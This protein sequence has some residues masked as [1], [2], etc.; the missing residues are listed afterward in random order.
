MTTKKL[1]ALVMAL[2]MLT[3]LFPASLLTVGATGETIQIGTKEDWDTFANNVTNGTSYSGCTVKLTADIG[4]A[5]NPVT[6]MVGTST[7]RFK[8]TLDGNGYTLTVSLSAGTNNCAPFDCIEDAT[9]TRLRIAGRIETSGKFAAGIAAYTYGSCT[10]SLCR[11]SVVIESSVSGDG[12]HGGFVGVTADDCNL[13]ISDC[14]FDGAIN[15]SGTDKCGGFVGYRL[16][17]ATIAI[18]NSLQAGT[19]TVSSNG[20]ATFSRNFTEPSTKTYYYRTALGTLQGID[21]A[22]MSNAD[23]ASNLGENWSV[24]GDRVIQTIFLIP[25]KAINGLNTVYYP[26]GTPVTLNY[27]VTDIHENILVE[28]VAYTASLTKNGEPCA[29]TVLGKG[30]Y[31]LTV[32]AKENTDYKGTLSFSFI[33]YENP[34]GNGSDN[35]PYLL[36]DDLDWVIFTKYIN[37]G[38]NPYAIKGQRFRLTADIGTSADPITASVGTS[39]NPFRGQLDGNGYTLTV[40]LSASSNDCAPFNYINDAQITRLRTA[41]T[42]ETSG[43]Y[44]AG[45]TA[46]TYGDCTISLCRSSVV[47]TSSVS[48]DGTHGGLVGVVEGG[49]TLTISDCL[50]D[51]EINGSSTHSC[52]GFVGYRSGTLYIERSLQNGHFTVLSSNSAT[53]VRNNASNNLSQNHC[54]Y[55]SSLG[56]TTNQGISVAN[57]SNSSI[58]S[59]LGD[60]WKIEDNSVVPKM[61]RDPHDLAFASINDVRSYYTCAAGGSTEISYTVSDLNGNPVDNTAYIVSFTKNGEAYTGETF[62]KG[63]YVLTVTAKENS[64]YT[65]SKSCSFAVY[66]QLRGNGS[67]NEPYLIGSM[68]DWELFALYINSGTMPYANTDVHYQLT[69]NIGSS[70]SPVTVSAGN[71]SNSFIGFFD[72]GGYTIYVNLNNGSEMYTALFP[73]ISGATIRNLTVDGSVTGGDFS[74]GLVGNA[75][76]PDNS[77]Q[78]C[79]VKASV[80]GGESIGGIVG[81]VNGSISVTDCVFSGAFTGGSNGKGAIICTVSGIGDNAVTN[82]VYYYH[83][84]DNTTNLDLHRGGSA[85]TVTNCYKTVKAGAFGVFAYASA[86]SDELTKRVTAAGQELYSEVLVSVESFYEYTGSPITVE[87]SVTYSGSPLVKDT[88]YTVVTSPGTVQEVGAYTLTVTGINAA[89]IYGSYTASLGVFNGVIY[90]DEDGEQQALEN[91]AFTLITGKYLSDHNMALSSGWYVVAGSLTVDSRITIGGNDV[92]LIL[93]NGCTFNAKKGIFVDRDKSLT[94]YAQSTGENAGRL[95]IDSVA[96]EYAGIGGNPVTNSGSV[97]INGGVI[98]VKGG[99]GA[100]GIGGGSKRINGTIIINGGTV[101]ATGGDLLNV[102]GIYGGGAGIGCGSY[103]HNTD[104]LNAGDITI[105]GG[106]VTA[107]GGNS[108]AGIGGGSNGN[109]VNITINGG[110]VTA[111]GSGNGSGIGGGAGGSAGSITINGGTVTANGGAGGAGIGSGNNAGGGNILI[112]GGTVTATGGDGGAGIGGGYKHSVDTIKISGGTVKAYGGKSG[113][114]IGGGELGAGGTITIEGGIIIE[115]RGGYDGNKYGGAGIGGGFKGAGGSITIT[116]GTVTAV[117]KAGG[118]GIGSGS[119]P[120]GNIAN[121]GSIIKIE[122]GTVEAKGGSYDSFTNNNNSGAGI[123]GGYNAD[124]GTI[125]ITG[126]RITVEA[127]TFNSDYA[128]SAYGIGAGV[129]K[130]SATI[131]LGLTAAGDYIYNK[132]KYNGSVTLSTSL[133]IDGTTT[134]LSDGALSDL[135]SINCKTLTPSYIA[136]AADTTSLVSGDYKVTD[137]IT[138]S[139]LITVSGSVYILLMDGCTL[140]A[141]AGILVP[142][143]ASLTIVSGEAGTGILNSSGIGAVGG[144]SCGTVNISGGVVTVTEAGIGGTGGTVSITGGKVTVNSVT[145]STVTLGWTNGGDFIQNN[146]SYTGAVTFAKGFVIDGTHT[147]LSGTLADNS[148]VGGKKLTPCVMITSDMTAMNDGLCYAASANVTVSSRISVTG[149]A[150]LILVDGVTLTVSK[151][152]QLTSGNTLTVYGQSLNTGKLLIN[153]VESQNAGIGG[154]YTN[155]TGTLYVYGG[156]IEV[157]GGSDA[158]GIGGGRGHSGGTVY[159][160]GGSVKANGGCYGAG[161]GGGENGSGGALYVNGGSVTATGNQNSA[162]IGGGFNGA[163]ATVVITSGTVTATGGSNGAGIGGGANGSG[164]SFTISGGTVIATCGNDG[165]GIGGGSNGSGGIITVSGGTVTGTV[166]KGG[167]AGLGSGEASS[168]ASGINGGTI[169]ITSGEVNATGGIGGAGIGGGQNANGGS[170]TVSGGIVNAYSGSAGAGIGGGQN[171]GCGEIHIR[172]GQVKAVS[173]ASGSAIGAGINGSGG[174]VELTGGQITAFN[175]PSNNVPAVGGTGAAITLGWTA[176][177]DFIK[178]NNSKGFSGT[179]TIASGKLLGGEGTG[180]TFSGTVSDNSQLTGLTLKPA[181]TVVFNKNDGSEASAENRVLIY[182]ANGSLPTDIFTREGYTFACWNTA[183][184]GTGTAY[185]TIAEAINFAGGGTPVTLYAQ[186]LE[187]QAPTVQFTSARIRGSYTEDNRNNLNFLFTVTFNSAKVMI[188]GTWHGCTG[189]ECL[190][191][192]RGFE[193]RIINASNNQVYFNWEQFNN[194]F[195]T[196]ETSC[197]I[198]IVLTNIP[199]SMQTTD[200]KVELRYAYKTVGSDETVFHYGDYGTASIESIHNSDPATPNP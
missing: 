47:I 49:S 39:A 78:N 119:A 199:W 41:G 187:G 142:T 167:G 93:Y 71:Q 42:I 136:M 26:S 152:I 138:V 60:N 8:G 88:D 168:S 10:I 76:G 155:N 12:T 144:D 104:V 25:L 196:T 180:S 86:P 129:G 55:K 114:G 57:Q 124:G 135:S 11:S 27:T 30:R 92:H 198:S 162:G 13:T 147:V 106:T 161:I 79:I 29:D 96:D 174:S 157:T 107:T 51:G 127:C 139:E 186:W 95:T 44:A 36:E 52:G 188:D 149:S 115:A 22:T 185:T 170:I 77:V 151:G 192:L 163:G 111:I 54:Y 75:V 91:S 191:V 113:A 90:L 179:V 145:G 24:H 173:T 56:T 43:K 148:S 18:N 183:S 116:S 83:H 128:P 17:K 200:F 48:G 82:C 184:D 84:G 146:G 143:D 122:G 158:A 100:A 176:P 109:A 171:A 120:G 68:D 177:T 46:H 134:E 117:G 9:I 98:T 102:A 165:A 97:T 6:I 81:F 5:S 123:G 2:F 154:D 193:A 59:L 132:C 178:D 125:T 20:S 7:N 130:S 73:K 58:R 53:F 160:Y 4:T 194:I 181:F 50:F 153:N 35:K 34:S 32:T 121:S 1:L 156:D 103:D 31:V 69:A 101:S 65:N 72:G 175:N 110:Y 33:V 89:G 190:Y 19:F 70:E 14:L 169:E 3:P 37:E 85:V 137:N 21:A 105:N 112:S 94:I 131:S 140:N 61:Y 195:E 80:R 74:A 67:D 28:D 38:I 141:Q 16:D 166:V 23:L 99:K 150:K 87:P 118:A 159:V 63:R 108:C 197:T 62:G 172:G 64:G 45:I 15:G 164:V 66:E 40:A 133:H 189:S 126:G 182:S